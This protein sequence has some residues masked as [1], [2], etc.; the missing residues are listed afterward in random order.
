M[1]KFYLCLV[2]LLGACTT[3][4]TP[5]VL[6]R[7][8]QPGDALTM[9]W[10]IETNDACPTCVP[11][12]CGHVVSH[13]CPYLLFTTVLSIRGTR[14]CSDPQ[15]VGRTSTVSLRRTM[16]SGWMTSCSMARAWFFPSVAMMEGCGMR[17]SSTR[18]QGTTKG[19][20][21]GRCSTSQGILRST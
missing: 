13:P 1:V 15:R 20:S 19:I 5:Q 11:K 12:S 14:R 8:I 10:N 21:P 6:P 9:K 18:P 16:S 17:R 7:I 4:Q 2:V 3:D